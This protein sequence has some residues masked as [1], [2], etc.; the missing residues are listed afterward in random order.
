M[1]TKK[2]KISKKALKKSIV[3]T[4]DKLKTINTRMELGIKSGKDKLK[5]IEESYEAHRKALEDTK[6]MQVYANNELEGTQFEI[7][8]AQTIVKKALDEVASLTEESVS[9]DAGNKKLKAKESKLLK[10]ISLLES[11]KEE[12]AVL[13][14]DI[15][16]IREESAKGHERLEL[17]AIDLNDL[18]TGVESY[19]SRKSAAESEFRAYKAKIEREKDLAAEELKAVKD[20]MAQVTLDSGKKMGKIDNVIAE[21]ITELRDMDTLIAK[22]NYEYSTIQFKISTVEERVRDAEERIEYAIKK[23]EEKVIKIKGEFKNWKVEALDEVARMKIKRKVET[24]DKAGLKDIL[25]G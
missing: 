1:F 5:N 12:L 22:K 21:R 17:L 4:N 7:A 16:H 2:P 23:E 3:N 9:L 8:E 13:T 25:D 14:A 15:K 24:I 20:R 19:I 11:R 6:E 10:T 18:N